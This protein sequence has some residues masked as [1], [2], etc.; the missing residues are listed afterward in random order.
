MFMKKFAGIVRAGAA[1]L[2]LVVV[3]SPVF[4][5]V[6]GHDTSKIRWRSGEVMTTLKTAQEAATDLSVLA[7][8]RAAQKHVVVQFD[9]PLSDAQRAKLSAAGVS[10]LNYV[11]D[12]AYFAAFDDAGVNQDA[13]RAV[14]SLRARWQ[15]QMAAWPAPGSPFCP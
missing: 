1:A 5:Q 9:G 14:S 11:G 7:G 13:L 6:A 10:L 3:A 15:R 8:N 2:C 12:N 4:A